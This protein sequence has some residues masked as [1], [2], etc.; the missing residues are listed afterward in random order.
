[1]LLDADNLNHKDALIP[2][3]T[4]SL[5]EMM[6][7]KERLI[8]CITKEFAEAILSKPFDKLSAKLQA[9]GRKLQKE[10]KLPTI[11]ELRNRIENLYKKYALV[12]PI[13]KTTAPSTRR[14]ITPAMRDAKEA[15][16]KEEKEAKEKEA[17]E[18]EAKEARENK[19]RFSLHGQI[20]ADDKKRKRKPL[21]LKG[22]HYKELNNFA[23]YIIEFNKMK[24]FEGK[25]SLFDYLKR[26]YTERDYFIPKSHR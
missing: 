6:L 15:Q 5:C 4:K 13:I 21:P 9:Y 17:K 26:H 16:E 10:D 24:T 2:R 12:K 22:T 20:Y 7:R 25:E 3:L 1:M 11:D 8:F 23:S 18:Q 19:P 14:L